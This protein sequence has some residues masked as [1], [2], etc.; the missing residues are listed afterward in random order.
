MKEKDLT[1]KAE[2]RHLK[3]QKE[4]LRLEKQES[5]LGMFMKFFW[6]VVV[7]ISIVYI[8]D[9]IASNLPNVMKPYMIFDLFNIFSS[10]IVPYFITFLRYFRIIFMRT[11]IMAPPYY[12]K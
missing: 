10:N 7:I 6:L 1:L 4:L 9:E 3:E 5:K 11:D 2:K 12:Q 8:A